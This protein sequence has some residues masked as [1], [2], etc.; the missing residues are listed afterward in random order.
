MKHYPVMLPE[1]LAALAP[2]AGEVYVDGTFG[3]GGYSE[4]FLKAAD[5]NVVGLDRDPNVQP[6]AGELAGLY[7]DRFRLIETPFSKMDEVGLS[8]VDAVVL[9]I[10]VSSMQLDQAERGFSFMRSG[11]LDMRMGNTGPTAADAVRVLPHSDLIRI[12]QVYGE[13][14]RA[15]RAA[16]FILRA[17]EEGDIVTTEELA[18]IIERALGRS[19]KN[20]P[21][22]RVFQALRIFINDEL[23][24]LYRGLCAAEKILKPG[25]RLIVVT[26][27]SLEDRIVKSFVR[28]RAGDVTGGSRYSPEVKHEGPAPSFLEGKRSVIKPSKTEVAENARSRSAKLRFAIRTEAVP[29]PM[30]DDLLPRV[31]NLSDLEAQL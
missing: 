18:D 2:Q 25:G 28:R 16:D 12:F 9:D 15:R 1:V 3:N 7:N 26:F 29:F 21:A 23:G 14:R 4:A 13:E 24:E 11:P 10:G 31:S 22:T 17:R 8:G 5:C 20:H 19:G 6:R 27:H 30:D